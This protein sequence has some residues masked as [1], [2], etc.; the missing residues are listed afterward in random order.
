MVAEQPAGL[1]LWLNPFT[2][3]LVVAT[4]TT[5]PV[6]STCPF[7]KVAIFGPPMSCGDSDSSSAICGWFRKSFLSI[8]QIVVQKKSL[9]SAGPALV[10]PKQIFTF[11]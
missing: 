9:A 1:W 10:P 11:I 7:V 8:G 5:C 4:P 6:P 3:P 2:R